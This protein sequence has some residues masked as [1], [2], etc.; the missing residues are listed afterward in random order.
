MRVCELMSDHVLGVT[1]GTSV[2]TVARIMVR[3]RIGSVCVVGEQDELIGLITEADLI[4]LEMHADP[5]RHAIPVD[6]SAQD[7]PLLA[8]D[9]MTTDVF[10]VPPDTDAADVASVMLED[11]LTRV[12]VVDG[13][14]LAG[15][16]SRSDLLQPLCRPDDEIA[17]DLASVLREIPGQ[18]QAT[19]REGHVRLEGGPDVLVASRVAWRVPGVA[20][21]SVPD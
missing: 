10:A 9:V 17:E 15:M 7:A 20:A 1:P 5:T 8:Q 18:W 19:V 3:E 4:R 14:R 2:R 16:L 11:G 21:V 13:L 12:P 6:V